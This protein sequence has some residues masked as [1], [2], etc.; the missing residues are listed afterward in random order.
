MR[1]IRQTAVMICAMASLRVFG[2]WLGDD[3][4]KS[5]ATRWLAE[6]RIAQMTMKGLSPESVTSR[7]ALRIVSLSPAGYIVFS[8]SDLTGPVISFSPNVY[9]EPEEGSPFYDMLAF[10][11]ESVAKREAEGGGRTEKWTALIGGRDGTKPTARRLL[12]SSPDE[13]PSTILIEPF[14]T[15]HWN[16]WQPW[17]DFCPIYNSDGSGSYRG[18]CPCGC[19]ATAV[20][21]QIAHF[22][23]PWNTGRRDSYVHTFNRDGEGDPEESVCIRFDGHVPFEWNLMLD[24]YSWW[25]DARGHV[26]ELERYPIGRFILWVDH[27]TCMNFG[28]NGSGSHFSTVR[29]PA[30]DWYEWW[31]DLDL[32]NDYDVSAAKIKADFEDR[33]PVHVGVP[34]HSVVAHGWASD[35][36]YDYVYLNYG[37]GGS[38][39]GW[40][41][42]DGRT[43][44]TP[45]CGAGVG[46]RPKKKVQLEPLPKVSDN[47][48]TVKWHL[49]QC[50]DGSVTGFEVEAVVFGN[51]VGDEICNFT[52]SAGVASDPTRIFVTNSVED[53]RNETDF[54]WFGSWMSGTYDLP[55]ERILTSGS[56]LSYRVSSADVGDRNVEILASFDGGEWQTVSRPI[57]CRNYWTGS[58]I[59]QEVFLGEHAGENV[60]FRIKVGWSGG[61]V[62]FDDFTVSDVIQPSVVFRKTVEPELRAYTVSEFDRGVLAGISVTPIFPDG[63]GIKSERE[64][65]RIAGSTGLPVPATITEYTINDF[66]Y[67]SEAA[68]DTWCLRGTAEGDSTIKAYHAWAGGFDVALPG[69]LTEESVLSFSWYEIGCYA[70]DTEYDTISVTFADAAGEE[71]EFWCMTNQNQQTEHQFVEIPLSRFAGKTGGLKLVFWHNGV[72]YV[73]DGDIMRFYSPRISNVAIP[74]IPEARWKTESYATCSEP[75]RLRRGTGRHGNPYGGSR[76]RQLPPGLPARTALGRRRCPRND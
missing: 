35:D 72:N 6:D 27:L 34:G 56:T 69:K 20:A 17:N 63:G 25:G 39:D 12:T 1:Q 68:N 13:D 45:I 71:T 70:L 11:S 55:G 49:P 2:E 59:S 30:S 76:H 57:L 14:V 19:V 61:S 28:K 23:W 24:T 29:E 9:S 18:R 3:A 54:L 41:I 4:I 47:D 31:E 40:Y 51:Q 67:T 53:V 16:Q 32:V 75:Q 26:D 52:D 43:A 10:S 65:T 7:D 60:R 33:V 8:G 37:W 38:S 58:W 66:V 22:K 73:G 48:V 44:D 74:V 42:L 36:E 64:L 15:T 50:Y 46:F 62:L 5:A 21:Q